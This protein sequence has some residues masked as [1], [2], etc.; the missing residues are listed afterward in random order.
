MGN[1]VL[2]TEV[3]RHGAYIC[4]T[5]PRDARARA[6]GAAVPVLAARLKL[7]SEFDAE[8]GHPPDAVAFLRRVEA[9]AGTIAADTILRADA[10][11][12]VASAAASPSRS[13]N[14]GFYPVY[15]LKNSSV[16]DELFAR[17]NCEPRDNNAGVPR[18][19]NNRKNASWEWRR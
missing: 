18:L 6:A 17:D 2:S 7:S 11:I 4:L 9:V 5:V 16:C 1:E 3:L 8:H 19:V 14:Q 15:A 13:V 10:V 12:H